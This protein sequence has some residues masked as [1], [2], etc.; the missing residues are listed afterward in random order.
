VD[1]NRFI[2]ERKAHWKA[3]ESLLE[4][5]ERDGLRH[6]SEQE[7]RE[8]GRLYRQASSDLNQAQTQTS[9]A[10]ILRY[11]NSLVAR[12]YRQIYSG[13][14]IRPSEILRFYIWG[15][16]CLVR[17]NLR[18]ILLAAVTFLVGCVF[19]FGAGYFDPSAG[20]FLLPQQFQ[21]LQKPLDEAT[22]GA[23][24]PTEVSAAFSS[25][26][27]TNNIKVSFTAFALG[28]TFGLGTFAVLFYNGVILGIIGA[29]FLR[30]QLSLRFW[31][32]ILPHG[33][34]ELTAIFIAG[35]AGYLLGGALLAPGERTRR[36]A[37]VEG[38]KKAIR[39]ILGIIPLLVLAGVIEGFVSPL[40]ILPPWLKLVF[41]AATGIFL[42]C[43][44]FLNEWIADLLSIGRR[45]A[46]PPRECSYADRSKRGAPRSRRL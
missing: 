15:F 17:E 24:L 41:A 25:R 22:E 1:L 18:A 12:S 10:E 46:S 45:E 14:A 5:V 6:L 13:R 30:W 9:N 23:V 29:Q 35:G 20:L 7:A 2:A 34:M 16:P 39:L 37:L 3:L 44:F 27:M 36:N 21:E 40:R 33:V 8:F 26:I 19:G 11:L 43:Y 31:A 4:T 38:G 28:I 42:L 32:T